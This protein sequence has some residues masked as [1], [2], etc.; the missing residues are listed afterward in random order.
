MRTTKA[1][2]VDQ[3]FHHFM[4]R[5]SARYN[6][7]AT[8]SQYE[9]LDK[10]CWAVIEAT[11]TTIGYH[12]DHRDLSVVDKQ[13]GRVYILKWSGHDGIDIPLVYD[14][15]RRCLVSAL[16]KEHLLEMVTYDEEYDLE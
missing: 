4:R 12:Q 9:S 7:I 16:P 5:L 13:S 8:R 15:S 3:L 14:K 11:E 10:R 2:S 1:K 6:I